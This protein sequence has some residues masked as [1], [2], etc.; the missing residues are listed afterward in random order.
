[1]AADKS[2]TAWWNFEQVFTVYR[3]ASSLRRWHK[4]FTP[5]RLIA[6]LE[7]MV[8]KVTE[9]QKNDPLDIYLP[10]CLKAG[11]KSVFCNVVWTG[12]AMKGSV[13]EEWWGGGGSFG[14]LLNII[15][16]VVNGSSQFIMVSASGLALAW[17]GKLSAQKRHKKTHWRWSL[18]V[19]RSSRRPSLSVPS[20]SWEI[21][22]EII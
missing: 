2:P 16:T 17:F 22:T 14:L 1:M 5:V 15:L 12:L 21:K 9:W 19:E 13:Y 6:W 10:V 3:F 8:D 7:L 4:Y 18:M 11:F 20:S